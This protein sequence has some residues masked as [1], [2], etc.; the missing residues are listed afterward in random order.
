MAIGLKNC[1]LM[2]EGLKVGKFT[3]FRRKF[4]YLLIFLTLYLLLISFHSF[5]LR[6]EGGKGQHSYYKS[7]SIPACLMMAIA[8]ALGCSWRN[9]NLSTALM[10]SASMF[11]RRVGEIL[12]FIFKIDS[13]GDR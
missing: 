13:K 10:V 3:F 9:S 6:I 5:S 11:L 7:L 8:V 12:E 2:V 4:Y 1:L